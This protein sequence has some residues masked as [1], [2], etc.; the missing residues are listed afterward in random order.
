[1]ATLLAN[2][3][4]LK[5]LQLNSS[6]FQQLGG[7]VKYGPLTGFA[8]IED[9]SWGNDKC[10]KLLGFYEQELLAEMVPLLGS[11]KVFIDIGAADGF[12]AV[13]FPK[14]GLTRRC[15]AFEATENGRDVIEKTARNLDL[16]DRV[17]VRGICTE[18]SLREALVGLDIKDVVVLCDIE[19]AEF[20]IMSESVLSTLSGASIFIEIHDFIENGS[21]LYLQL[22]ER[23]RRWFKVKEIKKAGRNPY[24]YTELD[25][26][27]DTDHWLVCSEGRE[28]NQKWLSLTPI[29]G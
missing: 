12:Y 1:M 16:L 9:T 14:V 29:H 11:G 8:L 13:G 7:V 25:H 27:D 26:L 17:D 24:H 23:A 2:A 28:P 5:R 10:A 20:E 3:I 22:K 18:A 15:I 6:V 4:C 19:G 21:D